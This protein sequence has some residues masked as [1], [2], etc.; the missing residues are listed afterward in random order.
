MRYNRFFFFSF[1]SPI[2]SP[3]SSWPLSNPLHSSTSSITTARQTQKNTDQSFPCWFIQDDRLC[4][5]RTQFVLSV[6]GILC[7][8]DQSRRRECV[9]SSILVFFLS[10]ILDSRLYFIPRPT[11]YSVW[12][13]SALGPRGPES[14]PMTRCYKQKHHFQE[15]RYKR[16]R[17]HP[18]QCWSILCMDPKSLR[19]SMPHPSCLKAC[20]W[21][22]LIASTRFAWT[23]SPVSLSSFQIP[24]STVYS[25]MPLLSHHL[26]VKWCPIQA[27]RY[28]TIW[29]LPSC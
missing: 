25:S 1:L 9:G 24:P 8:P 21:I 7:D 20:C 28:P 19:Y 29:K 27:S 14:S 13:S 22:S 2:K 17:K 18:T 26:L 11:C 10:F 3:S 15:G 6:V 5:R 12:E 23:R 4:W 16:V